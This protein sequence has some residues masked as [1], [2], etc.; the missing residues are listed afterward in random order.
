MFA[1]ANREDTLPASSGLLQKSRTRV[2]QNDTEWS[3]LLHTSTIR[4]ESTDKTRGSNIECDSDYGHSV[5]LENVIEMMSAYCAN[6]LKVLPSII[7]SLLTSCAHYRP[8][9]FSKERLYKLLNEKSA[10]VKKNPGK[11]SLRPANEFISTEYLMVSLD[12]YASM[13]C[14]G[15]FQVSLEDTRESMNGRAT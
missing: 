2:R 9:I 3:W 4:F 7:I 11:G 10:H 8:S 15:S 5:W 6:T 1:I 13:T 12:D 14:R